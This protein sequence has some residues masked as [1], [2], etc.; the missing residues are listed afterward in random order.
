ML[1]GWSHQQTACGGEVR[2]ED[3]TQ[4]TQNSVQK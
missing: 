2:D 4:T 1:D 3:E